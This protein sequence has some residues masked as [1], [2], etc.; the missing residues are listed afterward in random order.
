M[1]KKKMPV[2]QSEHVE[3]MLLF[4]LLFAHRLNMKGKRKKMENELELIN[5][6]F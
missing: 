1:A 5:N 2:F 4:L 3:L 6:M